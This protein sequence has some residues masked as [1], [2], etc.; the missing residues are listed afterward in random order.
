MVRD[1]TPR[2]P[3]AQGGQTRLSKIAGSSPGHPAPAA[4]RISRSHA[5][6]LAREPDRF[7]LPYDAHLPRRVVTPTPLDV[8][9]AHDV[10]H[11]G[12]FS[13]G[14]LASLPDLH[15]PARAVVRRTD[16]ASAV[17]AAP[18]PRLPEHKSD[19]SV[20]FSRTPHRTAPPGAWA[21]SFASTCPCSGGSS[22]LP[23]YVEINRTLCHIGPSLGFA[24]VLVSSWNRHTTGSELVVVRVSGGATGR[25]RT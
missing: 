17:A 23:N 8:A 2:R 9:P 6:S 25:L 12:G 7:T 22:D 11:D 5:E 14:S 21:S 18:R 4:L 10:V 24:P 3:E 1:D 13:S 20:S 15:Q 16:A 19:R